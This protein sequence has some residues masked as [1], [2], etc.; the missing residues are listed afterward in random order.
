[1]LGLAKGSTQPTPSLAHLVLGLSKGST[2]PTSDRAVA[3]SN[4][5]R[6]LPQPPCIHQLAG[7]GSKQFVRRYQLADD[8]LRERM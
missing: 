2:Q 4:L 8:A 7:A 3:K 6:R 1:M 5:M